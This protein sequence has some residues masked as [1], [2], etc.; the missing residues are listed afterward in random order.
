MNTKLY[1]FEK[2]LLL[3]LNPVKGKICQGS[4]VNFVLAGA[5]IEDLINLKKVKIDKLKRDYV[6]ELIDNSPIGNP[7]L[8]QCLAK[9]D[10]SSKTKKIGHWITKLAN[11]KKIKNQILEELH[12]NGFLEKK[13]SKV[14][15]FF[16][17]RTYPVINTN[18]AIELKES[19]EKQLIEDYK[20]D[21]EIIFYISLLFALNHLKKVIGKEKEKIYRKRI[22]EIAIGNTIGVEVKKVIDGVR[23]AIFVATI[24]PAITTAT[25]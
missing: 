18:I 17:Q 23:A 3:L 10:E 6:L 14:L 20:E 12:F 1:H 2:I 9:I 13:E 8:D 4:F 16:T 25:R 7:I 24:I 22:K 15:F 21:K 11:C 19:I 5:I